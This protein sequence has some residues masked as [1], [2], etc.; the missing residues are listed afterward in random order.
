[1]ALNYK[2]Y[3]KEKWEG[4]R[5]PGSG[6]LRLDIQHPLEWNVGRS[7]DGE[8][9]LVIVCSRPLKNLPSSRSICA[10]CG[11]RGDGK[12]AISFLLTDERQ[13]DVFLAMGSDL[14]EYST[15]EDE[16]KALH[17]VGARYGQWCRLLAH[18]G[19]AR[20]TEAERKGLIG[21]LLF[22]KQRL[23][24][25][26]DDNLAVLEGWRG[27]ENGDQ[28]FVYSAKWYEIKTT[29]RAAEDITISSAE[30]LDAEG[31]GEL[32][33]FRVDSCAPKQIGAFTLPGLIQQISEHLKSDPG[34]ED[35]FEDK[36]EKAGYM[37]M[38]EYTEEYWLYEG[39]Q[40]YVVNDMFPRICRHILPQE[41]VRCSYTLSLPGIAAWL[42]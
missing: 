34:A 41:I 32:I 4:L 18:K 42:K 1:M 27:P 2:E 28:D 9:A 5:Y 20:L 17:L 16:I 29:G 39:E 37:E 23:M 3:L 31:V 35:C 22:L 14:I 40:R 19:K 25:D 7:T 13:E 8:K 6:Y 11:K 15:N 12:Y 24:Q 21:E 10:R 38:P 26:G 33:I 30:Q 36:L